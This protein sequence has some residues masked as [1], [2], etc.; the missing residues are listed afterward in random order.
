MRPELAERGVKI[1]TVCTD[2]PEKLKQG[3][4]RHGLKATMLSDRDLKTTDH[5]GL[6]NV[7]QQGGL[8]GVVRPDLPVP[9]TLLIDAH[10][11]V[12]WK[13]QADNFQLRSDPEIVLGAVKDKLAS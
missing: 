9:T 10:G 12:V 5:F 7:S 1:V 6:R 11:I 8:P 13:D 4:E 2:T 3:I